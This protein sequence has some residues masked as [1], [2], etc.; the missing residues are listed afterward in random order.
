MME[1][2][3]ET[4]QDQSAE[5]QNDHRPIY[6]PNMVVVMVVLELWSSFGTRDIFWWLSCIEMTNAIS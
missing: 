5:R 2:E 4:P 1:M 3:M 6:H